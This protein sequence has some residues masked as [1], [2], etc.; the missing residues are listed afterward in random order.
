MS[1]HDMLSPVAFAE[2]L[3][4]SSKKSNVMLRHDRLKPVMSMQLVSLLT[5]GAGSSGMGTPYMLAPSMTFAAS[6][7]LMV[8]S[9][10]GYGF[11]CPMSRT[12]KVG[13]STWCRVWGSGFRV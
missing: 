5:G 11:V 7:S 9:P 3:T 2:A 8:L 13:G 1:M 10:S 4:D 6:V 12:T